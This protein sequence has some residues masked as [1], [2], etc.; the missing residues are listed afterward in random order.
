LTLVELLVVL[1]ILA[2]MATVAITS[3]DLLMGQGRYEATVRT[4]TNIERAVL[5]SDG[6]QY[7]DGSASASGFVADT[8]RIP[9]SLA[10]L[11]I[12][13]PD[14]ATVWPYAFDSD[15]DNTNDVRLV[16]GWNGPYLRLSVG[17]S[18]NNLK[19]GYGRDFIVTLPVAGQ[20][21]VTSQGADG[22]SD[23]PEEG[24]DQDLGLSIKPADYL[25][26]LS[27]HVYETDNPTTTSGRKVAI[28][29]YG[30]NAAG[31]TNGTIQEGL[32]GTKTVVQNV[33]IDFSFP[34]SVPESFSTV[35]GTAA[36]R[37]VVW[38]DANDNNAIDQGETV[39][40]KSPVR[41]ISAV[42]RVTRPPVDLQL[43]P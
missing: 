5:D 21:V 30:K 33:L 20:I 31:G 43:R 37:A 25:I 13:P 9:T 39:E 32:I 29:F 11:F 1:A 18:S 4:L 24:Y 10:E 28:R 26:D 34:A 2:L 15:G 8:G 27:F 14:L 3:T 22:N 6:V 42:P 35:A 41:Y 38:H 19:D 36:A 7:G 16:S 17:V 12:Q 40:K 23:L